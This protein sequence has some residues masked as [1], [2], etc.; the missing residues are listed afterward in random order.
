MVFVLIAGCQTKKSEPILSQSLRIPSVP[1]QQDFNQPRTVN[2]ITLPHPFDQE[3]LVD[4]LKML[5]QYR[6]YSR[7][8][9]QDLAM[10]L[11]NSGEGFVPQRSTVI[12]LNEKDGVIKTALSLWCTEDHTRPA[13]IEMYG[14]FTTWSTG[15]RIAI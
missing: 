10:N 9:A 7:D 12:F 3:H 14:R 8:S 11:I 2:L 13:Y 6:E 5:G 4:T 15:T 1:G